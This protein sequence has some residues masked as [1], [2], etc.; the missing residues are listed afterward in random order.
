MIQRPEIIYVEGK[1]RDAM[2]SEGYGIKMYDAIGE[3]K[4]ELTYEVEELKEWIRLDRIVVS[5]LWLDAK[6]IFRQ[7]SYDGDRVKNVADV[8]NRDCA[9]MFV[10]MLH[11]AK[12]DAEMWRK[13]EENSKDGFDIEAAECFEASTRMEGDV[14]KYFYGLKFKNKQWVWSCALVKWNNGNPEVSKDSIN[15]IVKLMFLAFY[16]PQKEV[17]LENLMCR[18]GLPITCEILKGYQEESGYTYGYDI[19]GRMEGEEY[20]LE[21]LHV[22]ELWKLVDE[23][24]IVFP[25]YFFRKDRDGSITTNKLYKRD[26]KRK[27]G[28]VK[29]V[30]QE[31]GS[32]LHN[33]KDIDRNE[34]YKEPRDDWDKAH[35][36]ANSL[37]DA[38]QVSFDGYVYLSELRPKM[39]G[40]KLI[41]YVKDIPLVTLMVG[42][43]S[44]DRRYLLTMDISG[45]S[46]LHMRLEEEWDR[47]YQQYCLVERDIGA[48]LEVLD[49]EVMIAME[50]IVE[51]E[52]AVY[53]E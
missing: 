37:K 12:T 36:R 32:Y 2:R 52:G 7:K 23:D 17:T 47:F 13:I 14:Y 46:V 5:N 43:L 41:L 40:E 45:R 42:E 18:R 49:T 21:K 24:K 34:Y 6:G 44:I 51:N 26:P 39:L 3:D 25:E 31:I 8:I 29:H 35:N 10:A 9:G 38:R 4:R 27:F 48:M 11:E 33:I 50:S 28:K 53:K 16:V 20:I 1:Q 30:L 22:S 15:E 19:K